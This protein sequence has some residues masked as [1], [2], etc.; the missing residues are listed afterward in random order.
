M[1]ER[2]GSNWVHLH[3]HVCLIW[4]IFFVWKSLP[5]RRQHDCMS[6]AVHMSKMLYSPH[7]RLGTVSSS[8]Y[9]SAFYCHKCSLLHIFHTNAYSQSINAVLS[10]HDTS[11]CPFSQ[12]THKITVNMCTLSMSLTRNGNPLFKKHK[13]KTACV[14][15]I[16]H[17]CCCMLLSFMYMH[18]Q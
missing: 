16:G 6:L 2:C 4:T 18:V 7:H 5:Y 12:P 11:T 8:L 15:M 10:M 1:I 3:E 9:T 14:D 17:Q 13:N